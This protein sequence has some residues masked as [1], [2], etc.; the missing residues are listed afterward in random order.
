MLE[1]DFTIELEKTLGC[2]WGLALGDAMGM[3]TE[4]L[5][6]AE[7]A[8]SFGG[9]VWE[10]QVPLAS[11]P[12]AGFPA[13]AVTDDTGQ[14]VALA[15][16][17]INHRRLTPEL[18]ADTLL[19]W[20][21][22][23]DAF[24]KGFIGPSTAQ[25]LKALQRGATPAEAGCQGRTNGG[26][27]RVA[28]V[29]LV[30]RDNW[31]LLME[32]TAIA[33]L[34]TH[35]TSLAISAAA[36]VS[37]AIAAAL[38]PGASVDN[39]LEAARLGAVAGRDYGCR[40]WT[41]LLERRLD[42]ALEIISHYTGRADRIRALYEFIGVDMTVTESVI[43]ALALVAV[44]GGEPMPAIIEAVNMGGDTDTIAAITGAICGALKGSRAFNVALVSRVE[45]V[46]N[47]DCRGLAIKLLRLRK[48]DK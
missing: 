35:G 39:V 38:V 16:A 3:P 6:P 30:F 22:E 4:F 15:R 12:R 28:P 9:R 45:T 21:V 10:L 42:L 46:N 43:T 5:T 1:Q 33:C 2:L 23:A 31:Q 40:C 8:G 41:P 37:A 26:A 14:A 29:A 19:Q 47:L 34:P 25:A 7:I 36:A 48:A 32:Q 27:M 24:A 11:H 44:T 20:A 17:L 13:G 18:V